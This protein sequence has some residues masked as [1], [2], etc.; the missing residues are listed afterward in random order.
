MATARATNTRR[1]VERLSVGEMGMRVDAARAIARDWVLREAAGLPGFRGAYTA[2]SVNW[3]PDDADLPAASDLD[4]MV[5]LD[6]DGV[7]AGRRKLIQDGVLLEV[8]TVPLDLLRSPEQV[9]GD[10]ALVGG[11]RLPSV[12]ADPTGHL[13]ALQTEVA[14]RFTEPAWV[15]R[16]CEHARSRSL[17]Y[18]DAIEEAKPLNYQLIGWA[19]GTSVTT[20]IPLVAALRNPTVRR[21]YVAVREL[22]AE[23]DRLDL[24]ERLLTCLGAARISRAQT[25]HHLDA[26]A[27]LYDATVRAMTTAFPFS[28]DISPLSRHV[29]I[30]GSCELIEQGLHRE[31][32]FWLVVTSARCLEV[33]ATDA[34]GLIPRFE[35][36]IRALLADLGIRSFADFEATREITRAVLP[37][38]MAFAETLISGH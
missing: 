13:T 12:I 11:F 18:L 29:A 15:R 3:L 27:E 8:S 38:V 4:V 22:L 9:L 37:D 14:R 26:L 32:V 21:R 34:P 30:G 10:F 35:P 36:Q 28:A 2:G 19:F 25:E 23:H 20:L 6:G 31:A 16:R 17:L 7:T 24:Y 5:V 1:Q 33:L